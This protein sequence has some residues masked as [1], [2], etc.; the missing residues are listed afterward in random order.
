MIEAKIESDKFIAMINDLSRVSGR[1][2][3]DVLKV[4]ARNVL[5][6]CMNWTKASTIK[7]LKERADFI[8]KNAENKVHS[9][10]QVLANW[11]NKPGH[12]RMFLDD[13]TWD[14]K[15]KGKPPKIYGGQSWHQV[16]GGIYP[17]RWS[18][19]RWGKYMSVE[20]NKEAL[21]E[22]KALSLIGARGAAKRSWLDAADALGVDI[23]PPSYVR[24]SVST[25]KGLY[26]SGKEIGE[27]RQYY[28][29]LKNWHA[30]VIKP[31]RGQSGQS[32]LERAIKAR[33]TAF[34]SDLDNGVFA[35]FKK[36]TARYPGLFVKRT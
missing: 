3:N 19:Q 10:K 23:S 12:P 16:A 27:G 36:R 17:R 31:R 9:G 34:R 18:A 6:S 33:V 24:S 4:Q 7:K 11:S 26:G 2:F 29:E 28:I 25:S 13:S 20:T 15:R 1:D 22:A 5:R 14:P 30:T 21:A 8:R 32:M 35:D